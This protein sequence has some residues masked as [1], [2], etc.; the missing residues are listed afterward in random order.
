MDSGGPG[1]SVGRSAGAFAQRVAMYMV[2]SKP[3]RKS[4]ALG[5]SHFMAVLLSV[6]GGPGRSGDGSVEPAQTEECAPTGAEGV[7]KSVKR[8]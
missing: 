2:I 3:K 8:E 4:I 6:D 7:R 1:G 5:V